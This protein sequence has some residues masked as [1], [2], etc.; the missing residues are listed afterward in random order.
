VRDREIEKEGS[1]RVRDRK[2]EKES[3]RKNERQK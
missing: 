1:G 3:K 2:I